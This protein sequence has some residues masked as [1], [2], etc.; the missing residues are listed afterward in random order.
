M[1]VGVS[2]GGV[3]VTVGVLVGVLVRKN[4]RVADG[5]G[6]I[7]RVGVMVGPGGIAGPDSL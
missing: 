4:G 2:V 6:V 5:R 1:I 7:V 3:P